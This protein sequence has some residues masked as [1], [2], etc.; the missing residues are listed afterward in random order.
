MLARPRFNLCRRM[1]LWWLRRT[2]TVWYGD[3]THSDTHTSITSDT[4]SSSSSSSI[5]PSVMQCNN[6]WWK[7]KAMELTGVWKC[8]LVAAIGLF[9]APD[10]NSLVFWPTY[11][12]IPKSSSLWSR[13]IFFWEVRKDW[14]VALRSS[15]RGDS[16][17]RNALPGYCC[18]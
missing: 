2:A 18:L 1:S 3:A 11:C 13:Q 10:T 7:I 12:S 15:E 4:A 16:F 9:C 6:R 8:Y 14:S 5:P 17:R